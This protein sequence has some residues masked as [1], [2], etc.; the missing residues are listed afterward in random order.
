MRRCLETDC[1]VVW[2]LS[3]IAFGVIACD[4]IKIIIARLV[5]SA[6]AWKIS[7]LILFNFI[8]EANRLQIYAQLFGFAKFFLRLKE[9]WWSCGLEGRHKFAAMLNF[10]V[11]E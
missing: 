8:C 9:I 4:A 7:L 3:A 11:S 6:I 5:G 10:E 1:R 2:K